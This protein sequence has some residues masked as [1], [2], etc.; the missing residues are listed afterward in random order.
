MVEAENVLMIPESVLEEALSHEEATMALTELT[1]SVKRAMKKQ[2]SQS[3]T[4]VTVPKAAAEPHE[5]SSV[6]LSDPTCKA[7]E[8][9]THWILKSPRYAACPEELAGPFILIVSMVVCFSTSCGS[10]NMFS[11]KNPM[12]RNKV[13]LNLASG[14]ISARISFSC[15]FKPGLPGQEESLEEENQAYNTIVVSPDH[16]SRDDDQEMYV[17]RVL[18][19]ATGQVLL[20]RRGDAANAVPGQRVSVHTRFDTRSS[21]SLAI[22]TCWLSPSG[23]STCLVSLGRSGR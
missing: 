19:S 21:L 9:T 23:Q 3:E 15:R 22:E 16:G 13:V 4:V 2:C 17:M 5:V 18:D 20:E 1:G 7:S 12:F 11:G 10:L 8:N 6:T 14:S